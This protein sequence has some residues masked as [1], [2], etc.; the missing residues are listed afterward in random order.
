MNATNVRR[1]LAIVVFILFLFT[2]NTT[3]PGQSSLTLFEWGTKTWESD[4]GG[5]WSAG[6]GNALVA[7][8]HTIVDFDNLNTAP[9]TTLVNLSTENV[10]EQETSL[11]VRGATDGALN[12]TSTIGLAASASDA[13]LS[14]DFSPSISMATPPAALFQGETMTLVT[15]SGIGANSTAVDSPLPDIVYDLSGRLAARGHMTA[16]FTL[17][18][19]TVMGNT[20]IMNTTLDSGTNSIISFDVD[21]NSTTVL[22]GGTGILGWA[23]ANLLEDKTGLSGQFGMS[24][25][26]SGGRAATAINNDGSAIIS[27]QSTYDDLVTLSGDL[28]RFIPYNWGIGADLYYVSASADLLNA[29]LTYG[30]SVQQDLTA[31]VSCMGA[32]SLNQ[33]VDYEVRYVDDQGHEQTRSSG[34]ANSITFRMGDEIDVTMPTTRLDMDATYSVEGSLSN[35]VVLEENHSV[36][37]ELLSWGIDPYFF[38][39]REGSAWSH[40]WP[41]MDPIITA[42]KRDMLASFTTDQM[43]GKQSSSATA[44]E[45][46]STGDRVINSTVK[47]TSNEF[48]GDSLIV[49][50]G[51]VLTIGDPLGSSPFPS[52]TEFEVLAFGQHDD[53]TYDGGIN[54]KSGGSLTINNGFVVTR[55]LNVD[56]DG[57]FS[58]NGGQLTVFSGEFDPGTSAVVIDG[59]AGSGPMM[60]TLTLCGGASGVITGDL[61]VGDNIWGEMNIETGATFTNANAFIGKQAGNWGPSPLH[62]R[63][64]VV[65]VSGNGA[66]WHSTGAL[67]IGGTASSN[68]GEGAVY[69]ETGG[70]VVVDGVLTIRDDGALHLDGGD[71]TA[72]SLKNYSGWLDLGGGSLTIDGGTFKPHLLSTGQSAAGDLHVGG[73]TTVALVNDATLSLPSNSSPNT[74]YVGSTQGSGTFEIRS[75][76]VVSS[77]QGRV[78]VYSPGT[79]TVEGDGSSWAVTHAY[80]NSSSNTPFDLEI[81]YNE[82]GTLSISDGGAVSSKQSCLGVTSSASTGVVEVRSAGSQWTTDQLVVGGYGRGFLSI[83]E[84]AEV[85]T[86]AA[87]SIGGS[88]TYGAVGQGQG[89]ARVDGAG[90]TWSTGSSYLGIGVRGRGWLDIT[91]GGSVTSSMGVIGDAAGA[92][93]E[94]LVQGADATDTPS[95]WTVA[96]NLTV[97]DGGAGRMYIMDGAEVSCAIAELGKSNSPQ[98]FVSV[99]GEGSL[100]DALG[101]MLVGAASNSRA[102]MLIDRGARVSSATGLVAAY[103]GSDGAVLVGGQ[104]INDAQA[105]WDNS[106]LLYVGGSS[107]SAGG[108]GAIGVSDGGLLQVGGTL[109]LW[110]GGE[111]AI[112]GGSV[113]VESFDN[114]EGGAF[115]LSAGVLSV[116]GGQMLAPADTFAV[117][118]E[119]APTLRLTGSA[120]MNIAG[121]DLTVGQTQSGQVEISGGAQ[122]TNANGSIGAATNSSGDVKVTGTGSSWINSGVFRIGGQGN[123]G[124]EVATGGSVSSGEVIIGDEFGG[125]GIANISGAGANLTVAGN[126]YIGNLG[127]GNAAVLDSGLLDVG[128]TLEIRSSG[129][130]TINGGGRARCGTFDNSNG[131]TFDWTNGTLGFSS[132]LTFASSTPFNAVGGDEITSPRTLEVANLLTVQPGG[133]LGIG[134]GSVICGSFSNTG[135]T[136]NWG[137]GTLGFNDNLAISSSMPFST[138]IVSPRALEVANVLTIQSGATLGINGGRVTC[139][140]LDKSAGGTF[141][142]T[143]GTLGFNNN[144]AIDS[145]MPFSTL[146]ISPRTLEVANVLTI[147]SGATL[148]I[149]G[150]RVTCGSLDKSAGGT[151]TWTSG[152]LGFFNDL[153]IASSTPFNASGGDRITSPRT[154]EVAGL[155]TV[156]SGGTLAISGGSVTVGSFDATAAASGKLGSSASLSGA[157]YFDVTDEVIADQVAEYTYS[158]WFKNDATSGYHYVLENTPNSN[159]WAMASRVNSDKSM[160]V[161]SRTK[162]NTQEEVPAFSIAPTF[163][164]WNLFTVTYK[165]GVALRAYI[166]GAFMGEDNTITSQLA[167]TDGLNIGS[168]RYGGRRWIGLLDDMAIWAR[169]LSLDEI[170]VLYNGGVGN[171]ADAL[172]ETNG[173]AAYWRFDEASGGVVDNAASV[174][175]GLDAVLAGSGTSFTGGGFD[176]TDG[177]L[178]VDGGTFAPVSS[179]A[180]YILDGRGAGN[181]TVNLINGASMTGIDQ[182]RVQAGG[183]FNINSS[184]VNVDSVVAGS[185]IEAGTGTL[186]VDGPAA[187]LT[188]FDMVFVGGSGR[189][190]AVV[191]RNGAQV[192]IG[193]DLRVADSVVANST[194]DVA[195]KSDAD[196]SVGGDVLIATGALSGQTGTM[197]V[198]GLGTTVTQSGV[199]G[200]TIGA[201]SG[202]SGSLSVLDNAVFTTGSGGITVNGAGALNVTGGADLSSATGTVGYVAGPSTSTA[203][204]DGADSTWAASGDVIV[205]ELGS[206]RM[207]ITGGGAVSGVVGMVGY[208]AGAEGDVTVSGTSSA[209]INSGHLYVG[210]Y[211][212][213]ALLISA[214]GRVENASG[215]VGNH[216]DGIGTVTVTGENSTWINNNN[217]YVGDGGVGTLTIKDGADVTSVRGYISRYNGSNGHITVKNAGSTWTSSMY[218]VVGYE[219]PGALTVEDGGAVSVEYSHVGRNNGAV[220]AVTVTG[221]NSIMTNTGELLAGWYAGSHGIL[222]VRAKGT[223]TNVDGYLGK[224][225]SAQGT[226]TVDGGESLWNNTGSLYVGGSDTAGGGTGAITVQNDGQ[227][228]VGG[229]LKLWSGGTLKLNSSGQ[230]TCGSF[231]NSAGGTFDWTNGTLGFSNNLTIASSAPFNATGGDEITS[232]RT[233]EVAGLLTVQSSGSF[234]ISGGSVTVGSFDATATS[235][236]KLGAGASV[237]G[238][239]HFDVANEVIPDQAAEYTYSV[240]FKNDA[241]SGHHYV[242][243]STPSTNNWAMASRIDA[244]AGDRSMLVASR[245]KL[246]TQEE[247]PI[248]SIAPTINNW[249]LFTVTYQEGVALRAYI[250]GAFKGE[251]DSL[252]SQLASTDGLN[253][254][255]DRRGGRRWIGLLDDAAIWDRVLSLDEIAML[256]NNGVGNPADALL[257]TNGLAAYWR[258]D[259]A[260][261]GVVDNAASLSTELDAIL[262]GSGTSFTGGGFD[263]TDGGLTVDGGSFAPVSAGASYILD[264]QGVGNPTVTLVDGA[265]M[266]GVDQLRVQAG[267]EFNINDSTAVVDSVVV[268]SSIESGTGTLRADG[269]AAS[270]TMSGMMFVGGSGRDGSVVL[271]NGAQVSIGGDLRVGDSVV[272]DSTGQVVVESD[273]DVLIDGDVL[274][275]T[276]ELS[277]QDGT[278]MVTG[279]GATFTQNGASRVTVGAAWGSSGSLSVLYNAVFTTGTGGITVNGDSMLNV[280]GGADLSTA[281]GAIGYVASPS[282][283]TTIVDG[284]GSTWNVGGDLEVGHNGSGM[285]EITDGGLVSIGGTLCV[286]FDGGGDSFINMALGGML[287]LNGQADDSLTSFLELIEG[288]AS[289]PIRYWAGWDWIDIN[290]GAADVD[291]TL[292]YLTEGDLANY[293]VLTVLEP[294]PIPEPTTLILLAGGLSVLS[295]RRRHRS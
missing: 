77:P 25:P 14:M 141:T 197:T 204:V 155:L 264:G 278:M 259:E 186:V 144:L 121:Q 83:T 232:P 105:T 255:A 65:R 55:S 42:S 1:G 150:G 18:D 214:G 62:V 96:G 268:G 156:Q 148:R 290:N 79:V 295:R 169:V 131:G 32:L 189:D 128:G 52:Y 130:L 15:D 100:L 117:D 266:T 275:A 126:A 198:T 120:S 222:N 146:I 217:L 33:A 174:S 231:D 94:V 293:T 253:I 192:S 205:G 72:G 213:G 229:T 233:L 294:P 257:E 263:F 5:M 86:S 70:R 243:E 279:P 68:G 75:G 172:L 238:G 208:Y 209:W 274:I 159:N 147:Q 286:D 46:S 276:G 250:N 9:L 254:G 49:E 63:K 107:T 237:D 292:S 122:M 207:D 219:D 48:I 220:G 74:V 180:S 152:T 80:S 210:D 216:A 104:G 235:T 39:E 58:F 249:N 187:S 85:Q 171:P 36:T 223:F 78:G 19:K 20:T 240:W 202:S 182:L 291:Y 95:R 17:A 109:K 288:Q 184:T 84:G 157:G 24:G 281:T 199:S 129:E 91:D 228:A 127:D 92:S 273:A 201:E 280:R 270:L 168:D 143:S 26:S 200:V 21:G 164:D 137:S 212:N 134:G 11:R 133:T 124:L 283:G 45:F 4:I 47:I 67:N 2:V 265:S 285:L 88:P 287:A 251:D 103:S 289:S 247:I 160:L 53:D 241:T 118:G 16:S 262:A 224:N 271:R 93:G 119:G 226:A 269:P 30:V 102:I 242:L 98:N 76:S 225:S 64:G 57:A 230:A 215:Q 41:L 191:L 188:T 114:T 50:N 90:S 87:S 123:G 73:G 181:P 196:V 43:P 272:A 51:G 177:A 140:S 178:N 245:T 40:T 179:G 166:N 258:F 44:R 161:A 246:N 12:L 23:G 37:L 267:G 108:S 158:T 71:V 260:S 38:S 132:D 13:A 116:N 125:E 69:V 10:F 22:P 60:Q 101:T 54:V 139:G 29:Y 59:N 282:T 3:A 149:N 81:G 173:L 27:M 99:S 163:N 193:G 135:G 284:A 185:S 35:S 112:V 261:G 89:V 28:S 6:N 113:I 190:G 145:S 211:T 34:N 206:G 194:G 165:E 176:F 244:D 175:T 277:G 195:V 236:G 239:G 8:S 106:G 248:F 167:S 183:E 252:T 256:Y 203:I 218:I 31:D 82:L 153:T 61:T 221:E 151:F 227:L 136:F 234:A 170:A 111:L 56:G 142:W 66:T 110:N 138:L 7:S 162:I 115:E 97:G 154:L